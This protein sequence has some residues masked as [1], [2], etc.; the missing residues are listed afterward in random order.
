MSPYEYEI[1]SYVF[2]IIVVA[3]LTVFIIGKD[4]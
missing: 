3:I 2:G 1:I 4:F